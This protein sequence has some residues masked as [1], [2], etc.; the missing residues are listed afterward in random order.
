LLGSGEVALVLSI[1]GICSS[2]KFEN[3]QAKVKKRSDKSLVDERPLFEYMAFYTS[4]NERLIVDLSAVERLEMLSA[5]LL[6]KVGD[7][8]VIRH[9]GETLQV[10]DPSYA[11]ELSD[12]CKVN[13]KYLYEQQ[14]YMNLVVVKMAGHRLA[15]LAHR[16][17]EIRSTRESIDHSISNHAGIVGPVYIDGATLSVLD[18]KFIFSKYVKGFYL[19]MD[20]DML[21][22]IDVDS[23]LQLAA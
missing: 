6:Q 10:V 16:M 21:E 11:I 9:R 7:R 15:L 19:D 18:V 14:E 1:D 3:A 12:V 17:D 5:K 8:F 2:L 23:D 13:D 20:Q 22:M 4:P